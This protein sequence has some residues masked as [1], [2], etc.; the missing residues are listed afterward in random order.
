MQEAQDP[1]VLV[2]SVEGSNEQQQLVEF[3]RGHDRSPKTDDGLVIVPDV[4]V[5][6]AS[7]VSLVD[8]W[9]TSAAVAEVTLRLGATETILRTEI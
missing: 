4:G 5:D 9:R 8:D 2:I 1:N 3:L 6:I 7:L